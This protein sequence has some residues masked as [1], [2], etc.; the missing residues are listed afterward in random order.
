MRGPHETHV[1]VHRLGSG[2]AEFLILLRS[3]EKQ[4]YWN[5]VAGGVEE[6]ETPAEAALR[7]LGEEVG[8][9]PVDGLLDLG[10]DLGYDVADEPPEVQAR[11]APDVVRVQLHAYAAAAPA[12]WE[13]TL[14]E[15]HVAYRWADE[16]D[17]LRTLHYEEPQ[18]SVRRAARRVSGP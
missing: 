18:E 13:P 1:V 7:E 12:G 14:N 5:L 8:L 9:A 10:D 3:P 15:E 17:A 2:G 11:F 16:H 4:G 6:G